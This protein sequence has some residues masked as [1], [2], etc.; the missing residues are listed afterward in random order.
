M[1]APLE[2]VADV[3]N[4]VEPVLRDFRSGILEL[5]DTAAKAAAPLQQVSDALSASATEARRGMA[6]ASSAASASRD[7]AKAVTTASSSLALVAQGMGSLANEL[8]I[9]AKRFDGVDAE[10]AKVLNELSNGVRNLATETAGFLAKTN[11]E[12]GKAAT[13]LS[14]NI[15]ELSEVLEEALADMRKA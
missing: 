11:E 8:A 3:V 6:E 7:A 4:T 5:R 13:Q 10:I 2:R 1:A 12:F 9:T 14:G 15:N